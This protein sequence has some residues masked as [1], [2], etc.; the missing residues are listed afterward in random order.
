MRANQ[1]AVGSHHQS[2]Q[3][4]RDIDDRCIGS[5]DLNTDR[6]KQVCSKSIDMRRGDLYRPDSLQRH[7]AQ[8][9]IP[10]TRK[11][12]MPILYH[13]KSAPC[14]PTAGRS[15][16]SPP[17]RMGFIQII[18]PARGHCRC[19]AMRSVNAISLSLRSWSIWNSGHQTALSSEQKFFTV[20]STENGYDIR[21][22][23]KDVEGNQWYLAEA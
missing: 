18:P 5:Y 21:A 17:W 4:R 10:A 20:R 7:S 9:G 22:R 16:A 11:I 13:K 3:C 14:V 2:T 6:G 19:S 15:G 23:R 12:L 8:K 1:R